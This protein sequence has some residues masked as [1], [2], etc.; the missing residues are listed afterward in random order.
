MKMRRLPDLDLARLALLS[1]DQKRRELRQMKLAFPPYSYEPVRRDILDILNVEAGPLASLPRTPWSVI[2]ASIRGRGRSVEEIEANL[3][4][5][6]GLYRFAEQYEVVGRHQE[7]F[8]L[9]IGVSEKVMFWQPAV[10]A[11]GG[12]TLVPF[13]DPRK[14]K[15]LTEEGR[16]FVFSVMHER[17]RAADLDYADVALGIFQFVNSDEGPRAPRLFLDEGLTLLDFEALDMMV[18]E[19]YA[20]W[21]EVLE[22]REAAA[23][24]GT[25]TGPLI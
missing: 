23:R 13:I 16:L 21:H 7:F 2:E 19:T 8:A 14:A 4:V 6:E 25:G 9:P 18:R 20:I 22:E 10:V 17:I 12:K 1:A 24:R 5:A 11:V 15:K 3:R